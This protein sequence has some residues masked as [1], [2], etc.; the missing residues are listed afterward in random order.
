MAIGIGF[1]ARR[2]GATP[3]QLLRATMMETTL[4]VIVGVGLGTAAAIVGVAGFAHARVGSFRIRSGP[5][6]HLAITAAIVV[7]TLAASLISTI[8]SLD[9]PLSEERD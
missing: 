5:G 6:H 8:R 2:I 1:L 7:L 9:A 4:A 3:G